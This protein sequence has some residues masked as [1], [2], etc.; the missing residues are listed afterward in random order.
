M[1][2]VCSGKKRTVE[3]LPISLRISMKHVGI[4]LKF[5]LPVGI[6]LFLVVAT[7]SVVIVER[8]NTE[9]ERLYREQ[10]TTL[11]VTSRMMIH[12]DAEEYATSKGLK[13]HRVLLGAEGAGD[14][15]AKLEAEALHAL[16]AD[17]S[18]KTFDRTIMLNGIPWSH[19]YVPARVEGACNTCH[20]AY[21]IDVFGGK[22]EGEIVSLFGISGSLEPL[23]NQKAD[24]RYMALGLGLTV[25]ALISLIINY[26]VKKVIIHPI[27]GLVASAS[28]IGAGDLSV[29]VPVHSSDEVG[30]LAVA[31]N[32]MATEMKRTITDVSSAMATVATAAAQISSSTRQMAAG[33]KQ[34]S[35]QTSEVASAMEEMVRTIEENSQNAAT[36]S[37]TATESFRAAKEGGDVARRAVDSTRRIGK[38]VQNFASTMQTLDSSSNRIGEIVSVINDIADQT[39]LLALNAAIEA[40]RAGEQGRGF[41]VVADEVR[42]LAERTMKATKE[43]ESMIKEIQTETS[44]AVGSLEEGTAVVDQGIKLSEQTGTMLDGIVDISNSVVEVM[45]QIAGANEAQAEASGHIAKSIEGINSVTHES[46]LAL[47]EMVQSTEELDQLSRR[48]QQLLSR[49]RVNGGENDLQLVQGRTNPSRRRTE[50][51]RYR[52][53]VSEDRLVVQE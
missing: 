5:A 26:T 44:A 45:K 4:M 17:T 33:T 22:K 1:N 31:F 19:V 46:T 39:N 15:D 37:E 51:S 3:F 30:T 18:L 53:P 16:I 35:A 27:K 6:T 50:N 10:L 21:G 28:A 52:K 25:L 48:V 41:A 12:S 9:A 11:A 8:Q 2:E 40:A 47:H 20:Q 34:Q 13:F 49:F 36:T 7:L 14:E 32:S 38:A 23:E 43:I 42:K 29:N 24:N